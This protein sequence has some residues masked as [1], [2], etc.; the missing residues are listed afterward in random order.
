MQI[1]AGCGSGAV[2]PFSLDNMRDDYDP[3]SVARGAITSVSTCDANGTFFSSTASGV[4]SKHTSAG[5]VQELL[6]ACQHDIVALSFVPHNSNQIVTA[7]TDGSLC[8]WNTATRRLLWQRHVQRAGS[9]LCTCVAGDLLL[10]G[11]QDGC[12]RA[13]HMDE[14]L[15]PAWLMPDVHTSLDA[16]GVCRL[17]TT[18][19][20][21]TCLLYTSPSPRD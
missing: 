19:C 6:Q 16:S 17:A 1:V 12:I 11:F 15:S 21:S 8:L 5:G 2:V 4:L 13:F 7:S 18:S 3:I 20:H 10:A 9:A 14:R